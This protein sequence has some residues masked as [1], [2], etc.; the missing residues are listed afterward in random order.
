MSGQPSEPHTGG[1]RFPAVAIEHIHNLADP[2][3]LSDATGHVTV[4]NPAAE[5]FFDRPAAAA[6]GTSCA[7]LM[8]GVGPSASSVCR[9]GCPHLKRLLP[10]RRPADGSVRP[11]PDM[12]VRTADD[13]R[14]SVAVIAMPVLL[15]G[16]PML[17]HLL[18]PQPAGERDPLTQT[19]R[20]DAFTVRLLD[21][22]SRAGRSHA[23]LALALVDV[24]RLKLV[25]DGHGHAV[26]DRVL[27]SV[28]ES[29]RSGRRATLVGR[30][31]GDEFAVL[32]PDTTASHAAQGLRRVLHGVLCGA[33]VKGGRITFSAGVTD[34]GAGDSVA[35]AFSRADAALY[36]AKCQGR[37]RVEV[38]A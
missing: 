5:S 15:D 11:H 38:D 12:L 20:R 24:D 31:G 13:G 34:I 30:W 10:V 6:I 7:A 29:L 37:A 26:G 33:S 14:A 22:Q 16:V 21:E 32:Y 17:L 3:F 1:G 28:A 9:P 23:P 2:A 35:A 27:V 19:L 8:Q 36:R 18:R 25:N 4:W